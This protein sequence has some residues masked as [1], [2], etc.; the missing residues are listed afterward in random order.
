MVCGGGVGGNDGS[1]INTYT[2]SWQNEG[3][4]FSKQ[5]Q[6]KEFVVSVMKLP[7]PSGKFSSD[8]PQCLCL[9]GPNI[10][11]NWVVKPQLPMLIACA[12]DGEYTAP[13][14]T[15]VVVDGLMGSDRFRQVSG[16][17]QISFLMNLRPLETNVMLIIG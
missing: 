9:H 3:H 12:G 5:H 16:E 2:K 4:F 7:K 15:S 10:C 8:I 13:L 1:Q 17:S 11:Q 6:Q 14:E